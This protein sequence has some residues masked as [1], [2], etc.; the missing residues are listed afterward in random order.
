MRQTLRSSYISRG[1]GDGR[2]CFLCMYFVFVTFGEQDSEEKSVRTSK[3]EDPTARLA[4]RD[5]RVRTEN[6]KGWSLR[7]DGSR[8]VR[9]LIHHCRKVRSDPTAPVS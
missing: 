6:G 7:V 9:R 2:A 8:Q 4:Q 3:R 5:S 1:A